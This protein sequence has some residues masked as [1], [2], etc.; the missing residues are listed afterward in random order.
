MNQRSPLVHNGLLYQLHPEAI[1]PIQI[2]SPAW[3]DRLEQHNS[4][5]YEGGSISF[6]VRKEKRAG[7]CYWYAHRYPQGKSQTIYLEKSE[8]LTAARLEAFAR[9][10]QQRA[11]PALPPPVELP[12]AA[13]LS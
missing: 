12:A 11:P 8:D 1:P 2:G 4:F 9:R 5:R 3:F 7:G 10:F 6:T 13:S